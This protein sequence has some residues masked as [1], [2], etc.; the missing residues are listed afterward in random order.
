MTV[1]RWHQNPDPRLRESGDTIDTHQRRVAALCL[2]LAARMGLP[3]TGSDLPHAALHHDEA[4]R[5]LGDM[6]GPAKAAFPRLA[7][8]YEEAEREV[9][10]RMGLRW[11]LTAAETRVLKLCDR[12]DAWQWAM[13]C[14]VTGEEWDTACAE[15]QRQAWSLGP[16]AA[17]WLA[18]EMAIKTSDACITAQ[19]A[20]K[21]RAILEGKV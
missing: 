4:E 12:L 3:M 13:R 19:D 9:L 10:A 5:V 14:D 11:T 16:D 1:A 18:E 8:A 7:A 6:P 20:A 17:A 21:V 2:S 15:I